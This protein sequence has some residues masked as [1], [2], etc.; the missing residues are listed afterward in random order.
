MCIRDSQRWGAAPSSS[1]HPALH[2][3][4]CIKA[5]NGAQRM[6]D[7][8]R[9][10]IFVPWRF[11]N[12]CL[13]EVSLA[14]RGGVLLDQALG[15][16]NTQSRNRSSSIARRYSGDS[17]PPGTNLR[18]RPRKLGSTLRRQERRA[19]TSIRLAPCHLDG[20]PG[21]RRLVGRAVPARRRASWQR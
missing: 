15:S 16:T 12:R 8:V 7:N 9:R 4:A 20:G 1:H 17:W 19:W 13:P 2:T 11:V 5:T 10:G 3:T 14:A 18:T 6:R 21:R